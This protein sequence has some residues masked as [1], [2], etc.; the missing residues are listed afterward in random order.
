MSDILKVK[1]SN[2]ETAQAKKEQLEC[3]N[4]TY[5]HMRKKCITTSV[6]YADHVM[7][8][9]YL[10]FVMEIYVMYYQIYEY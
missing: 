3:L 6:V 1:T 4:G 9:I 2:T 10:F 8:R 5:F 7:A